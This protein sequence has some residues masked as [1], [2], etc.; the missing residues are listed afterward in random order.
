MLKPGLLEASH[1]GESIL[2]LQT[3]T[4]P[5]PLY[6]LVGMLQCSIADFYGEGLWEAGRDAKE[7]IVRGCRVV[8]KHDG[9]DRG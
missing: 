6:A 7:R 4:T 8:E 9:G 3:A 5:V 2:H 1:I